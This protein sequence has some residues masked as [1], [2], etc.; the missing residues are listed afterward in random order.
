[1]PPDL[2]PVCVFIVGLFTG[3]WLVHRAQCGQSPLPRLWPEKKEPK[4]KTIELPRV[5]P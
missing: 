5:K 3:A 1:M 4:E 2:I